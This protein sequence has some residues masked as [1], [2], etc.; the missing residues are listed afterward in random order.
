MLDLDKSIQIVRELSLTASLHPRHNI[1]VDLRKTT[2][3]DGSMEI[4]M[5]IVM[6]FV[7]CMPSF[8]KKIA[9]LIPNDQRR[10]SFAEMFESCMKVQ[11]FQY[12]FFTNYEDA[13]EWLSDIQN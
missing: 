7:Q 10:I 4:L 6:E 5:K 13:I 8:T 2:L 11:N 9:S 3:S 12:S 1:L